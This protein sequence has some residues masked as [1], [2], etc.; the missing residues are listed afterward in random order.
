MGKQLSL[1]MEYTTISLESSTFWVTMA[2]KFC[3]SN[4]SQ[5]KYTYFNSTAGKS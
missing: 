1:A 4:F 3:Y 2:D 5:K